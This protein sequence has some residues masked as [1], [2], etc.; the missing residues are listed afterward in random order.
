[1]LLRKGGAC[2]PE[3]NYLHFGQSRMVEPLTLYASEGTLTILRDPGR[4]TG[5]IH[6]ISLTSKSGQVR[7]DAAQKYFG[8]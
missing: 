8:K 2:Q 1:M 3:E 4:G 5:A 7:V 6:D